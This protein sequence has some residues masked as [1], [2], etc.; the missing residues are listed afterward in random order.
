MSVNIF[1]YYYDFSDDGPENND[2]DFDDD[3]TNILAKS[4]TQSESDSSTVHANPLTT[5][6]N[7]VYDLTHGAGIPRQSSSNR[8]KFD[9]EPDMTK[10]DLAMIGKSITDVDDIE[11]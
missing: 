2:E 3:K 11:L 10:E 8:T 4:F 9:P 1:S 6:D 7:P 5:F